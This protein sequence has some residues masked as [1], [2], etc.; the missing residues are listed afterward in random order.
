MDDGLPL[1]VL[2]DELTL[3]GRADVQLAAVTAKM[4]V[5]VLLKVCRLNGITRFIMMGSLKRYA[6]T[7]KDRLL[8][9]PAPS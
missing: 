6:A 1:L 3:I 2:V 8:E 5:S 4:S 9:N 7:C